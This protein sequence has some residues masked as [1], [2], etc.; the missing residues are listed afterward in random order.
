MNCD[1][2]CEVG[3]SVEISL[4][5]DKSVIANTLPRAAVNLSLPP[6]DN[7]NCQTLSGA[8]VHLLLLSDM[9]PITG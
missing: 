7:S 1:Y 4:P 3:S 8:G 5:P 2:Q 9:T 6:D